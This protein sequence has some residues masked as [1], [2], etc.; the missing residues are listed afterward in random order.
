MSTTIEGRRRH[1]VGAVHRRRQTVVAWLFALPFVAVFVTF[2]AGPLLTSLG[3]AVT[4][5]S[6]KD[7][8]SPFSVDVVWLQNV[9]TVL[10]DDQFRRALVNTAIFVAIG[11]PLTMVLGMTLAVALNS[12][13]T[14]FRAVFR[15]AFYTPV[16]TSIVAVAVVWRFMLQDSGLVNTMLGWVGLSGVD[17]LHDTRTALGAIILLAAWRNM[18]TLMIIYLAGLQAIPQ[19]VDEAARMDGA[20]AARRFFGVTLPLMRP[21]LLL[22]AVLLSVGFLQVFEEPYVMTQGGP[23]DSTLTISYYVYDQFGYGNYAIAS[24]AA[25]VLFVFIAL[26]SAVQFRL[27]RSKDA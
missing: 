9:V 22:G 21:T 16:V 12:G 4:D 25:Y 26:L 3:M 13:V 5:F 8:R 14:R 20:G 2:M 24:A 11:I 1:S 23:L 7:I 6:V 10:Q 18:G 15:A 19:E 27:L 17:W